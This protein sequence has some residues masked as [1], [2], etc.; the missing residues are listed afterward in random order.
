MEEKK[1]FRTIE[2][3][4]GL[5]VNNLGAATNILGTALRTT[6]EALAKRH[7]NQ[8]GPWLDDMESILI[9]EAKGTIAEGLPIEVDAASVKLGIDILQM[10]LDIVRRNLIAK[11]GD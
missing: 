10:Q 2:V 5:N 1:P 8:A 9:R 7:G 4:G 6:L 11:D 3:P